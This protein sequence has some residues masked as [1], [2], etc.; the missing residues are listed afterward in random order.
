MAWT[1]G[2]AGFRFQRRKAWR[3]ESSHPHH[4]FH[5]DTNEG[6]QA[7]LED[8]FASGDAAEISDAL[9][10][11]ARSIGMTRIAERAGISRQALHK[12]LDRDS[13]GEFGAILKVAAALG[14]ELVSKRI[15]EPA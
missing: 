8:A 3:F 14:F 1:A 4:A 2:P 7:H 6:A 11:V 15:A 5:L 12:A 9:G 10:V 13:H